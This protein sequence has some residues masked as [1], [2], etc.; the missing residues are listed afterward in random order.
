MMAELKCE[1]EQ[2]QGR[3]IFM[4]MFNDIVWWTPGNEEN[5]VA[6]SI[7]VATYAK[8]FLFGCWSYLGLDC[9]KKWYGT[10]VNK[11]NGEWNRVGEIMMI[12][13]VESGHILFKSP[14]L[15]NVENWKV[16][17]VETMYYNESEETVVHCDVVRVRGQWSRDQNGNQG[18]ES[19]NETC[20]KDSQSFSWLVVWQY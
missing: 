1:P 10:H 5:C 9:E 15:W 12:N 11:P 7:N 2:L 16:K 18:Q 20:V 3:I 4:T 8:M 13:F 17:V 19:N 14:V 6:N